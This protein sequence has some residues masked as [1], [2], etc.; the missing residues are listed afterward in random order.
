MI[1]DLDSSDA[2][3]REKILEHVFIAELLQEAAFGS[4]QPM[5]VEVLR[6]DVDRYG[7]DLV[8]T[9]DGTT[10]YVQIKGSRADAK[11]SR[12]TINSKLAEKS[13][14]CVIWLFY[15]KRGS[16]VDLEYLV[17]PETICG[18]LD[19]GSKMGKHSKG[20]ASG[21]KAERP[22]TRVLAKSS[23]TSKPTASDLLSWLFD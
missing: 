20:D 5:E 23:F 12:Q 11:R 10:R 13:G 9:C 22:N 21:H 18:K 3:F 16:R 2:S 19:L 17:Y 14:A 15:R 1:R 4:R 7:Y 8:L 6:P